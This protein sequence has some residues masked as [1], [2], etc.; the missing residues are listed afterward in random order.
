MKK[1]QH[2]N[3]NLWSA[4]YI[5]IMCEEIPVNPFVPNAPFLYPLKTLEN[6]CAFLMLSGG[7]ERLH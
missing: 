4:I 6:L 2:G 7:R 3:V 1:N 5:I